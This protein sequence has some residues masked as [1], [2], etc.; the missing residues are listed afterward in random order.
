MRSW[1]P[2]S[3]LAIGLPWL[4]VSPANWRSSAPPSL[5]PH[6]RSRE[7]TPPRT[8]ALCNPTWDSAAMPRWRAKRTPLCTG[9][10]KATSFPKREY[11]QTQP[12]PKVHN[13]NPSFSSHFSMVSGCTQA[14]GTMGCLLGWSS[15]SRSQR[16][17][18]RSSWATPSRLSG[19]AVVRK[20][21]NFGW[22]PKNGWLIRPLMVVGCWLL[23]IY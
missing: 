14:Q 17:R 12:T 21:T 2:N 16:I 13:S 22:P 23:I 20:I 5:P 3:T 7:N 11:N 6:C 9:K 19:S 15:W 10:R 4:P 8:E 1:Y 18:Q